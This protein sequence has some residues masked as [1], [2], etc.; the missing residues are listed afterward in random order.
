MPIYEFQAERQ[1]LITWAKNKG[2]IGIRKYQQQKNLESI[3]G[4]P[5]KLH[6]D[7]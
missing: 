6:S 2:E 7:Q 3:D 5:T 1:T 4:L